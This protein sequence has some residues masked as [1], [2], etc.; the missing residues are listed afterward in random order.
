M[1]ENRAILYFDGASR[2]NPVGPA[3]C[4]WVLYEMDANGNKGRY[5]GS[6]S[7]YLGHHV[8]NNQAEY[9]G[10]I[11]GLEYIQ[12]E[13]SD[14]DA[15]YVRGD[16]QIVINQMKGTYKVRSSNISPLY[17]E[18]WSTINGMNQTVSFRHVARAQNKEADRLASKAAHGYTA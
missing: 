12:S 10:L 7:K 6:G 13:Y 17:K 11:E 8:S 3:G 4:G 16:S 1:S 14:V 2:N 5:Y 9:H 15:L 18:A